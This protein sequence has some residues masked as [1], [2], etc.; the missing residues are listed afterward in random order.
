L[1]VPAA[2]VCRQDG[3]THVILGSHGLHDAPPGSQVTLPESRIHAAQPGHELVAIAAGDP[4]AERFGAGAFSIVDLPQTDARAPGAALCVFDH[5]A[6][7]LPPEQVRWLGTW[8]EALQSQL[9]LFDAAAHVSSEARLY[10]AALANMPGGVLL[11]D[12]ELVY[13]L[14]EGNE[15]YKS[16]GF[17]SEELVGRSMLDVVEADE[18]AGPEA[19]YRATLRGSAGSMEMR[20]KHSW[21]AVHTL[22]LRDASG[23][24]T[25]GMVTAYNVT[26][27]KVTQEALAEKTRILASILANMSEGLIVADGEGKPIL[28]N[29]SGARILGGDCEIDDAD[30]APEHGLYLSDKS[31]RL[32]AGEAP[33]TR[34]LNGERVEQMEVFAR[35]PEWPAGRWYSVNA[36]PLLDGLGKQLGGICVVRDVTVAK[37]AELSLREQTGFVE[38]LQKITLSANSAKCGNEALKQCLELV[39]QHMA[40][41]VGHVYMYDGVA[42]SLVPSNIW[43]QDD[44]AARRGLCEITG[45]TRLAAGEGLPGRVL[46]TARVEWL[47]D[48][49]QAAGDS[50]REAALATGVRAAVAFPVL[51]GAEVVAVLEFFSDQPG[52]PHDRLLKIMENVGVQLGRAVERERHLAAIEALSLTDELTGLCN[53]RGFLEHARRQVKILRRQRR[54]ALL[55]FA[56]LD[57]LKQINDTLG[58]EAGDAA[59]VAAADVLRQSFRDTDVIARFGGDEFVVLVAETDHVVSG[60]MLERIEGNLRR[61]NDAAGRRYTVAMSVGFSIYDPEEPLALEELLARADAAM[62]QQKQLRKAQRERRGSPA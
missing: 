41:P 14:A 7:S 49:S 36:N 57:G 61:K 62:Y 54:P 11:F 42:R 9:S 51:I 44:P 21:Y 50:R 52:H 45:R 43:H 26:D 30:S 55:F 20:R 56:D 32:G 48:M 4:A 40:W 23:R 29:P 16:A 15:L 24:V 10:K 33:L 60:R 37:E 1:R 39:C 3:D 34:A 13:R 22:P 35:T 27:L 59:I 2:L 5:E 38:L 12:H 18:R 8:I 19:L 28:F 53:R 17:T 46:Q 31:T 47:E 6:R 25:H 58:H